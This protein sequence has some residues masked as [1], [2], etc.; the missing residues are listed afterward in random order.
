ME[1]QIS[2]EALANIS[3]LIEELN[4]VLSY[5]ELA[6]AIKFIDIVLADHENDGI[7]LNLSLY[8]R[9]EPDLDEV[10]LVLVDIETIDIVNKE[11]DEDEIKSAILGECN[12]DPSIVI[13]QN[14][15]SASGVT[16]TAI[17]AEQAARI[18]SEFDT[19][20]GLTLDDLKRHGF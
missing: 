11:D 7:G 9:S 15:G 6:P 16:E 5:H 18:A 8:N 17:A 14:I 10:E 4:G 1:Y 13:N 2:S 12:I 19:V 20:Q 3:D